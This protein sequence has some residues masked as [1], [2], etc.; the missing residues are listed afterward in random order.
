[1]WNT[2]RVDFAAKG[3][4]PGDYPF[5]GYPF[6]GLGW[7]YD[8]SSATNDHVGVSEFVIRRTAAVTELGSKTPEEFCAP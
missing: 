6:T 5:T 4:K 8:W 2:Y 1:M 3:K 7:S